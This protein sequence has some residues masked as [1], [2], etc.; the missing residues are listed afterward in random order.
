MNSPFVFLEK[1]LNDIASQRNISVTPSKTFIVHKA[2]PTHN[3]TH[4]YELIKASTYDLSLSHALGLSL[5]GIS[6]IIQILD[7]NQASEDYPLTTIEDFFRFV[8]NDE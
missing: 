1:C 3:Q 5:S 4:Q 2:V 6:L 7:I 8:K